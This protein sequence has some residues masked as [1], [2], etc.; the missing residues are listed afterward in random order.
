MDNKTHV[1]ISNIVS[2]SESDFWGLTHFNQ[3]H[4]NIT[5]FDQLQFLL[6][7]VLTLEIVFE[8]LMDFKLNEIVPWVLLDMIKE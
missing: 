4:Q 1:S 7:R 3:F 6:K 2:C 5:L 8:N